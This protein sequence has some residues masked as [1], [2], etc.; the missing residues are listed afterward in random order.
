LRKEAK[1]A[2]KKHKETVNKIQAGLLRKMT[3]N[4]APKNTDGKQ[5]EEAVVEEFVEEKKQ[6]NENGGEI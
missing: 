1:K 6:D 5:G 4:M 2:K 3:L